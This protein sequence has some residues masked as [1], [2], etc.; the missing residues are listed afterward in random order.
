[1]DKPICLDCG[2][3][4]APG[5]FHHHKK[6]LSHQLAVELKSK[7]RLVE[8]E[9][10]Y[11]PTMNENFQDGEVLMH[12]QFDQFEDQEEEIVLPLS[13]KEK[14]LPPEKPQSS[15]GLSLESQEIRSW[16][17]KHRI[18]DNA[19]GELLGLLH[20]SFSISNLASN[21]EIKKSRCDAGKWS[22]DSFSQAE[23]RTDN[24]VS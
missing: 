23:I 6:L 14:N 20:E 4:Y 7:Q 15:P 11:D 13:P 22:Y 5:N 17:K 8:A 16:Q 12:D 3:P 10:A 2:A 21:S 18:S 24:E 19:M 9:P 1:M